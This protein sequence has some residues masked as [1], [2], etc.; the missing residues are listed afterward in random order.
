MTLQETNK[1]YKLSKT[2]QK[3]FKEWGPNLR[4]EKLKEHKNGKLSNLK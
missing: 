1:I 2:K 4:D 3:K